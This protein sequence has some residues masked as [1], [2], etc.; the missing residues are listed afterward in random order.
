MFHYAFVRRDS[1]RQ[2]LMGAFLLHVWRW[3]GAITLYAPT[4]QRAGGSED[5]PTSACDRYD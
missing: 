5:S 4:L 2:Q 3:L 1:F